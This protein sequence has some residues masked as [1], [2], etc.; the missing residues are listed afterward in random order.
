MSQEKM[1]FDDEVDQME[2]SRLNTCATMILEL[3]LPYDLFEHKGMRRKLQQVKSKLYMLFDKYSSK[4]TSYGVQ[5]TIQDQSSPLQ[6]K[7]KSSSHGLF[8]ELK[9]HHQ[10]LVTETG[11]WLYSF[12][13]DD[14]EDEDD[15]DDDDDDEDFEEQMN[16]IEGDEKME[17]ASNDFHFEDDGVGGDD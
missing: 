6:K 15:D 3:D 8:D 10:Q 5:G 16:E 9:V 13:S 4:N 17:Q 11:N 14:G 12:V 2:S 1:E 7:L